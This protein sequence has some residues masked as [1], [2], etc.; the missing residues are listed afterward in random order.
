MEW[1]AN[2]WVWILVGIGF[3]W[4][5]SRGGAGMGCCG[6]GHSHGTHKE[7]S[8]KEAEA[9]PVSSKSGCH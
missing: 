8:E 2:N 7:G 3:V 4:L 1:L 6:G 9:K 5:M